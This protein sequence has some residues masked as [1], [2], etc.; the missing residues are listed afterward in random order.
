MSIG[1]FM[2]G[3]P[4]QISDIQVIKVSETTVKVTWKTN[5]LAT[6]KINYGF[7]EGE[8]EK[9]LQNSKL[10]LDHEFEITD[11]DPETR[12][13]FEVMSHGKNY[14]YDANRS[15]ITNRLD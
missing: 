12:Y 11:L 6:G 4:T 9:E 14:V 2:I 1:Y 8:Y 13:H 5:H 3:E 7:A 15:F 10:S